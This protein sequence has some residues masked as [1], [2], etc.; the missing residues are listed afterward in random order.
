MFSVFPL[1]ILVFVLIITPLNILGLRDIKAINLKW[2]VGGVKR[3]GGKC[4]FPWRVSSSLNFKHPPLSI[5]KQTKLS[6]AIFTI[7]SN[8]CSSAKVGNSFYADWKRNKKSL[9]FRTFGEGNEKMLKI[10]KELF[11][12]RGLSVFL[13][14]VGCRKRFV[15]SNKSLD[16][17]FFSKNKLRFMF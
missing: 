9:I 7:T 17:S 6:S 8:I 4:F 16:T 11:G 2:N 10:N 15:C 5:N 3:S 13:C 1:N 14:F 12:R